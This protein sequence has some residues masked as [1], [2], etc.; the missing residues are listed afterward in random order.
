MLIVRRRRFVPAPE[1]DKIP[2]PEAVASFFSGLQDTMKPLI[3]PVRELQASQL[4]IDI[5][6]LE[7]MEGRAEPYSSV[8]P[9]VGPQRRWTELF[10]LDEGLLAVNARI[11]DRGRLSYSP[12]GKQTF[13]RGGMVFTFNASAITSTVEAAE[14]ALDLVST[15]ARTAF[16]IEMAD[17]F[18]RS[19][20]FES[21]RSEVSAEDLPYDSDSVVAARALAGR[22]ARVLAI[23]VKSSRGLLTKD[24]AKIANTKDPSELIEQLVRSGVV[25]RDVVVVCGITQVQVARVPDKTSLPKLAKTGLRCACGK[26]IDQESSD[27]LLTVTDLGTLLL[28]K[29]R[30]MSILVR[31]EL[32]KLGVRREDI[33]LECQL[34]TDEIDCIALIAGR[35][36]IFELKDK[37]FSTGNAYSFSA[38]ISLIDPDFSLIV[39]TDKVAADV[40]GRFSRVKRDPRTSR[41]S[42]A[43]DEAASIQYVEGDDF[44]SGLRRAVSEIYQIDARST[45]QGAL[46]AVALDAASVLNAMANQPEEV[47]IVP[48]DL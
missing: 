13:V 27:D 36:A 46:S 47:A 25:V 29:S 18:P 39:T 15:A 12:A 40:K 28:D 6:S 10:M 1:A 22:P 26:P 11:S 7:W 37:E 23:S 45:L 4:S 43:A 48:P 35:V 16:K 2:T 33:L 38:K 32:V 44:R 5:D 14:S 3:R 8:R 41:V 20:K 19:E 31:E 34:G 24:V 9:G 30:W 21:L 42:H 17:V